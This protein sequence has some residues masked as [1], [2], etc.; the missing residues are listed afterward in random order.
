MHIINL[1]KNIIGE[2]YVWLNIIISIK[3]N[4]NVI[5]EEEMRKIELKLNI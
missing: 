4:P 1:I 2:K 3:Y 5:S